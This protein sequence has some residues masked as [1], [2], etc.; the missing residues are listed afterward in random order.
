MLS[1]PLHV[2]DLVDEEEVQLKFTA[3]P[4]PGVYNFTVFLRSD[5]YI[6]FDQFKNIKVRLLA[7]FIHFHY[8]FNVLS[9]ILK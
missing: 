6:D 4:K 7:S 3:P 1:T 8:S 2:T 5:S 9:V